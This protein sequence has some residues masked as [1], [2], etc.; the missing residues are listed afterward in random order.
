MH[1]KIFEDR[2]ASEIDIPA[3][4]VSTIIPGLESNFLNS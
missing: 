3:D 2:I 1:G 4:M